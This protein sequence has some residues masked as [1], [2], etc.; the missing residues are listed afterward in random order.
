V[1]GSDQVEARYILSPALMQRIT[2]FKKNSKL[3][4]ALSFV[5]SH[6]YIALSINRRLFEAPPLFSTVL[7]RKLTL[8]YLGY[9][10][11][12]IEIVEALDLNTRIWTKE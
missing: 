1:Y 10:N 4:I 6:V 11:M 12:C 5:D 7:N 3:R 8:Q 2:E 9:L